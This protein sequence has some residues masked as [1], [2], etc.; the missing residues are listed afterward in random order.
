MGFFKSLR[1]AIKKVDPIGSAIA[2]KT[3][4]VAA[5]ALSHDPLGKALMKNDPLM[6]SKVMAGAL[7]QM[8]PEMAK[9]IQPQQPVQPQQ[10]LQTQAQPVP[11]VV[12][13]SPVPAIDQTAGQM[14]PP[15]APPPM[16]VSAPPT[17]MGQAPAPAPMMNQGPM[18]PNQMGQTGMGMGQ[19]GMG[20]PAARGQALRGFGGGGNRRFGGGY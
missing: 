10:P 3:H 13:P 12:P 16:P 7:R 9:V 18:P 11:G 20:M 8:N 2:N 19:R 5:K 4:K 14:A 1:K 15:M 17:P 6:K